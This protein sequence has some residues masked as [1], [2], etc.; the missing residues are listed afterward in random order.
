MTNPIQPKEPLPKAVRRVAREIVDG[1]LDAVGSGEANPEEA[2]HLLRKSCKEMRALVRLVRDEIGNAVYRRENDFYRDLARRYSDRR[3]RWVFIGVLSD[4][5]VPPESTE[6][7]PVRELL[8]NAGKKLLR[9][10]RDI[11][12][13][14][15]PEGFVEVEEQLVAAR[16]RID[17]WPV[18]DE[19]FG[20][21]RRSIERVYRRG[22]ER[23]R[24]ALV[25]PSSQSRHEWRKRAKYL[26]HQLGFLR[27]LWPEVMETLESEQHRLSDLLGEE[28]DLAELKEMLASHPELAGG[29]Q[30]LPA[31]EGLVSHRQDELLARAWPL[32]ARLY[33]EST[34]RFADRLEAYWNVSRPDAGET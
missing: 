30:A 24:D 9:H 27:C 23:M 20:T 7:D 12:G 28:H 6:D 1:A 34:D 4:T 22:R 3:D 33:A 19:G 14:G 10:H 15:R 25:N 5:L 13:S 8:R 2:I 31:I 26:Y 21:I 17:R 16:K 29:E 18:G 11:S 32:G